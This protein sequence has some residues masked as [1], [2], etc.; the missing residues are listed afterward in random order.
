MLKLRWTFY[1]FLMVV[2][3]WSL[4][5]SCTKDSAGPEPLTKPAAPSNL[6]GVALDSVTISLTWR[7][8]S[9][10]E[11]GFRIYDWDGQQWGLYTA[12][13]A[14]CTHYLAA[15]LVPGSQ[16]SYR[17]K[18]FNTA[19]E[20]DFSN[21]IN[22]QTPAY[23]IPPAPE[24]VTAQALSHVLVMVTW[25]DVLDD[26]LG[27]AVQRRTDPDTF[28]T[29]RTVAPNT[30]V[31]SDSG[32][33]PG[34]LYYYRV[35]SV[36]PVAIGWSPADTTLT[37][38]DRIPTAPSGL[39]AE[40]LTDTGVRL[41]WQDNSYNEL[42][43]IIERADESA[44]FFRLDSV[45]PNDTTY[46][47]EA[48]VIDNTYLYQVRASGSMGDSEPSNSVRVDYV[49]T[50]AGAIPLAPGNEWDY[51]VSAGTGGYTLQVDVMRVDLFESV[52]WFLIREVNGGVDTSR[53][54]RNIEGLVAG[55]G[56]FYREQGSSDE[57]L[58]WKYPALEGEYYFVEGDCV[59]VDST[60]TSIQVPAG[61]FGDCYLYRRFPVDGT[62]I[63]TLLQPNV[64]IVR[65]LTLDGAEPISRQELVSYTIIG[66]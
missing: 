12:T 46:L 48:V 1:F 20:S 11:D 34:T 23:F 44:V 43:F 19:G 3:G 54:L 8:N 15:D 17:V 60:K 64:G 35:G 63:E 50:S 22:V 10:N 31:F 66:P 39:E 18:A 58:L 29:I 2:A 53:Y 4:V 26:E 45:A 14:D 62:V 36:G 47:D 41:S 61:D 65:V 37:W 30:T 38:P 25:T 52:P 59:R 51:D 55:S 16:Y 33:T 7:D 9:T 24:D 40:L 49:H 13:Q 32:L 42:C 56:V 21:T 5:S 27:Y 28:A 6:A 57:Q